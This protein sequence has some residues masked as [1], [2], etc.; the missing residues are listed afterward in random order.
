MELVCGNVVHSKRQPWGERL[1]GGQC[2]VSLNAAQATWMGGPL[3]GPTCSAVSEPTE[4]GPAV[5]TFTRTKSHSLIGSLQAGKSTGMGVAEG[6]RGTATYLDLS[7]SWSMT[8]FSLQYCSTNLLLTSVASPGLEGSAETHHSRTMASHCRLV[9]SPVPA[10]GS[11]QDDPPPIGWE[12]SRII[13]HQSKLGGRQ[14]GKTRQTK[15]EALEGGAQMGLGVWVTVSMVTTLWWA[16]CLEALQHPAQILVV[17]TPRVDGIAPK[18]VA[19]HQAYLQGGPQDRWTYLASYYM[20]N[21]ALPDTDGGR[22]R[23]PTGSTRT[24]PR[25]CRSMPFWRRTLLRR[26]HPRPRSLLPLLWTCSDPQ[27]ASCPRRHASKC[28]P[29]G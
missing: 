13:L 25:R 19:H 16:E 26:I 4:R 17:V 22:G 14:L 7:R 10:E 29:P 23:T 2:T 28:S 21:C 6:G 18:R 9:P 3:T 12:G 20:S 5:P 24:Q 27:P 1:Q 11:D 8:A 15:V